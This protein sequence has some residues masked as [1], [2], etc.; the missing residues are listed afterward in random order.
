M[1]AVG[2]A[3]ERHTVD[4]S[5]CSKTRMGRQSLCRR[6]WFTYLEALAAFF[7]QEIIRPYRWF[8]LMGHPHHCRPCPFSC[9][10]GSLPR[11][12][13]AG[14]CTGVAL[15]LPC[16][17]PSGLFS[18]WAARVRHVLCF[19][20]IAGEVARYCPSGVAIQLAT[21][22]E[23]LRHGPPVAASFWSRCTHVVSV[24]RSGTSRHRVPVGLHQ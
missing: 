9:E 5:E 18:W 7:L 22:S 2:R 6:Y 20:V 8:S 13:S 24:P 15:P 21:A 17:S 14:R 10:E 11:A 23:L 16:P 19:A 3:T 1:Q 4:G 12:V